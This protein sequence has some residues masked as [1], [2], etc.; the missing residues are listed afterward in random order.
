MPMYKVTSFCLS[1]NIL[2]VRLCYKIG[3][4][5]DH[6]ALFFIYSMSDTYC[7]V[8]K[9]LFF[10]TLFMNPLTDPGTRNGKSNM[11]DPKF[12]IVTNLH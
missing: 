10:E 4:L 6:R 9:Y 5:R 8:A 7:G 11:V 1:F 2:E 3:I 12:I